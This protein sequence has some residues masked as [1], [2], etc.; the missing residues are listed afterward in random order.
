MI[1]IVENTLRDGSYEIN[2]QFTRENTFQ[3]V[4][5]LDEL[6][7]PFIEVGHGLGLGASLNPKA[8]RAK[9]TDEIYIQA[10]KTA[11]RNARIGVFFIPGI[12]SSAD[13][14]Q[15][16]RNGIDFIR[17]GQNIDK[18]TECRS[19]VELAKEQGLFV[20]V[21]L[22]KSY[23]VKSY[24]F[25]KIVSEIDS[26]GLADVIYLVDS[27]GCMLP[28]QV[29]EYIDR[30]RE[31]ISTPLG[32]HGHNNL[33]LAVANS[34][35]AINAGA[36]YIDSCVRG[37]GRSAGNAQ[38]EILVH[39]L[40]Q[41]NLLDTRIDLYQLYDFANKSIVP[42]MKKI[43]GLTDEEIHI[44]VSRFHSTFL[45]FAEAAAEKFN[46]DKRKLI[47][48][49]S[50]INCINPSSDLFMKIAEEISQTKN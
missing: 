36:T 32:F 16:K 7:F 4:K 15:A 8:G 40:S 14:I 42:L 49:V 9:E 34:L 45:P 24:E 26:W 47:K 43:Q 19:F 39:L 18:V 33:S 27:A 3:I 30:T 5:G 12:G 2:F 20:C 21:N 37:M 6:G 11:A 10:A 28:Q 46:T 50:E 44:G 48:K 38:T 1:Q 35:E 41:M 23:G 13:I 25:T 31:K 22:M 29:F 17:I